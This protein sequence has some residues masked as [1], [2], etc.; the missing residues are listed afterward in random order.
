M[1]RGV[2]F[3]VTRYIAKCSGFTQFTPLYIIG[4]IRSFGYRLRRRHGADIQGNGRV[5]Q[6]RANV[7]AGRVGASGALA[8]REHGAL[9]SQG[10]RTAVD[11][12]R[13]WQRK[14]LEICC[15]IG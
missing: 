4:T 15:L 5:Q 11:D 12:Q 8:G 3:R 7:R 6:E 10:R 13:R 1:C 14:D 2:T 9:A